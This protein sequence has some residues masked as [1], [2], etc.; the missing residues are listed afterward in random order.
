MESNPDTLWVAARLQTLAPGWTPDHDRA[1]ALVDARAAGP[2]RSG[3]YK[4]LATAA[5]LLA[6]TAL[7]PAGRTLAQELWYRLFV[8]RVEVVRL[9]LSD[10]P[11]DTSIKTDGAPVP[12][13]DLQDAAA[14]AG[15]TPYLVSSDVMSQLPTLSVTGPME[16]LQTIHTSRL[17]AALAH[18]GASDLKVPAAWDGVTVRAFIGP[19]VVAEYPGHIEVVQTTPIRLELPGGFQLA[20][21]A[22]IIFRT[23]GLSWWEA[24]KLGEEFAARPAWLLDVPADEPAAITTVPLPGGDGLLIE[25]V[26]DAGQARATIVMSRPTRLY[27]VSSPSRDVTLRLASALL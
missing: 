8:T 21:F 10:V 16:I 3:I 22:E 18:V 2:R 7:A 5:A 25:D 19:L 26:N 1:R 17:E 4:S 15:F 14:Q 23:G 11:L 9:D 6:I 12:A 24:R 20:R 27:T 13:T